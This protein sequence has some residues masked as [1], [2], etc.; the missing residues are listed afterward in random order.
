MN[1]NDIKQKTEH[2]RDILQGRIHPDPGTRSIQMYELL[3]T[4]V[5]AVDHLMSQ[6]AISPRT[7]ISSD[8]AQ[9]LLSVRTAL[10]YEAAGSWWT[11]NCPAFLH[12]LASRVLARRVRIK[13][14]RYVLQAMMKADPAAFGMTPAG[15]P[16]RGAHVTRR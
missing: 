3:A 7:M 9:L 1:L 11:R 14:G 4:M 10:D 13:H 8:C 5:D 15:S 6:R 16:V 12:G 2:A